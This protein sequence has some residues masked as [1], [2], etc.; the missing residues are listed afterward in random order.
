MAKLIWSLR[1]VD[2]LDAICECTA[3]DSAQYAYIFADRAIRFIESVP[4]YPF[5]GAVVQEYAR[6][7]LRE[8]AFQGY[9][10]VYRVRGEGEA[11]EIVSISH[12]AKLLPPEAPG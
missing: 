11:I 6:E 2:D 12:G 9:R 1:A 4:D 8:R 7:D 10:I 5:L 3:R